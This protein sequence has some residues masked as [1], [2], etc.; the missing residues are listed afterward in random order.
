MPGSLHN[1][2]ANASTE[3]LDD[4]RDIGF[5]S[6]SERR[7]IITDTGTDV[8]LPTSRSLSH[9]GG[10]SKSGTACKQPDA[11]FYFIDRTT[12]PWRR[13][14]FPRVVFEVGLSQKRETLIHDAQDWLVRS[15]GLVKVVVVINMDEGPIPAQATVTTD[16]QGDNESE[17]E[18]AASVTVDTADNDANDADDSVANTDTADDLAPTGRVE[19]IPPGPS[20]PTTSQSS[21]AQE[22]AD[23]LL[24]DPPTKWVGP[25]SGTIALYRYDPNSG[26]ARRESAEHVSPHLLVSKPRLTNC[27]LEP[28]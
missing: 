12:S 24:R 5:L 13:D 1:V 8:E 11:A 7:W 28:I 3:L 17:P 21:T 16:I 2:V 9:D 14:I 4:M 23:D 18:E 10:K 19:A 6:R 27:G 26:T 25:I 22:Y 20:S 15:Q